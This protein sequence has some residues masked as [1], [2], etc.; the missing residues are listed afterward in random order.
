MPEG[1][2]FPKPA[3]VWVTMPLTNEFIGER[4]RQYLFTTARLKKDV[5]IDQ[6]Q[7]EMSALA[8]RL[9]EQYPKTNTN[10][11]VSLMLLRKHASGEFSDIFLLTLMGAVGFVLMLACVNVANM[12]L[13][14]ASAR[15]KEMAIRAAM[16]ASRGRIIRQLLTENILLGLLGGTGGI[17][18]AVW[19][20]DF[21]KSSIPPD[22]T[23][24]IQGWEQMSINPQ[25][26]GF[27][28]A[29]SVGA[30]MLF[31]L[32]PA[33]QVS[34]TDLNEALKEGGK[35]A[36]TGGARRRLRS[37]LVIAEVALALVLLVGAGL[38]V[39][40]FARLVD[41]QKKG[42]DAES[43][44]SMRTSLTQARYPDL[45]KAADFYK[46][47]TER[48]SSMPGVTS[49]SAVSYLPG[50]GNWD[51]V[52]FLIEGRAAPAPGESQ[53][54]NFL[55][56]TPDYF[57]TARI[58]LLRGRYFSASDGPDSP[59]VAIISAEFAERYFADEDPMG[60]RI[61]VGSDGN[62]LATI[63]GVVGDVRRFMF[64]QGMT[65][66]IY[67]PHSQAPQRVMS[68]MLRAAGDPESLSL[69]ARSEVHST[70]ADQP[71]YE[72][73]T[74]EQVIREQY[75][76]IRLAA[77]LMAI[78]GLIAL[79]LSAVGVYAVM[80]YSVQQRTQE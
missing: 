26:L 2:D 29:I 51:T 67:L 74:V 79:A 7:A 46:Q 22:I 68:F 32:A 60:R 71:V 80:A 49:A 30:G 50:S 45:R 15:H 52:D 48:L 14:R 41:D 18:I 9:A 17:L 34:K 39:R 64:D 66:T 5:S 38:M 28:L 70:D 13:A 72:I 4:V 1:F 58:P 21:I 10:R 12:Q 6:A 20:L 77:M 56:I 59:R 62:Q 76:G 73:K 8:A 78:F 33:L 47:V 31:G 37:L 11:T 54:A 24:F 57:Q 44:L 36:S 42:F 19:M 65:P 75:S 61:K 40:G 27:T 3:E 35:G 63:V 16:G 23:R 53:S 43:V 69:A 55:I 25:V